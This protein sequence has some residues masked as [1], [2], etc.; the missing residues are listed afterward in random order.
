M[1]KIVGFIKY[2]VRVGTVFR[3]VIR[4]GQVLTLSWSDVKGCAVVEY[5]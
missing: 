4:V 3:V 5:R 2:R 1:V